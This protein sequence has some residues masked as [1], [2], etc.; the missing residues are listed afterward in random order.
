LGVRP[1]RRDVEHLS[2]KVGQ[3]D[4]PPR[5]EPGDGQPRLASARG[6]VEMPLINGDVQTPGNRC[7][8]R[9]QLVHDD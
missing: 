1:S 5:R 9:A 4:V 2:G 7:A 6:D 8:D 3:D